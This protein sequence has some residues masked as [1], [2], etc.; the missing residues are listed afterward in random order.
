MSGLYLPVDSELETPGLKLSLPSLSAI[1][2]ITFFFLFLLIE[3]LFTTF[4]YQNLL[5]V[6]ISNLKSS[7]YFNKFIS[8]PTL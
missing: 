3:M 2:R 5:K 7:R 6:Y 4:L 1:D 8:N